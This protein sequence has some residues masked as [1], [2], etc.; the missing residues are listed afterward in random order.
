[1][2]AIIV[3]LI[4]NMWPQPAATVYD[5]MS[6]H[7]FISSDAVYAR[8]LAI[9]LADTQDSEEAVLS[10]ISVIVSNPDF[11]DQHFVAVLNVAE[12]YNVRPKFVIALIR[13]F[14]AG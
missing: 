5:R 8:M 14:S 1:M 6:S 7:G 10:R 11:S 12:D 9:L 2:K 13:D 3:Y 4:Q